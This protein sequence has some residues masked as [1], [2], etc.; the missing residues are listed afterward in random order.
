MTCKHFVEVICIALAFFAVALP[1]CIILRKKTDRKRL[2][3]LGY[4]FLL[5]WGVRFWVCLQ[6]GFYEE[7]LNIF[8]KLVDS[9]LH[10]LQTFSMDE[11]YTLYLTFGKSCLQAHGF[12]F[13]PRAYGIGISLLN[14]CAPVLG[15]AVLL[16]ILVDFFPDLKLWIFTR[17][18]KFVFSELNNDAVT[19]A[20]D[21]YRNQ[22]YRN[23][24]SMGKFDRKPVLL[25]LNVYRDESETRTE[26]LGRAKALGAV[27][28]NTD[29]LHISLKRS[30]TVNYFLIDA[31]SNV[32]ICT[33]TQLL[34][35]NEDDTLLWPMD[36]AQK[37]PITRI[38]VFGQDDNGNT[39]IRK[40]CAEHQ[41]VY[42]NVLVRP[43]QEHMS[44]AT[45]LMYDVP[46][47]LPLFSKPQHAQGDLHLTV[48]G[49]GELA[50]EV[51]KAFYWCGQ[52]TDVRLH[53]RVLAPDGKQMEQRIAERYPELLESCRPSSPLLQIRPFDPSARMNPPYCESMDFY[54][55]SD[56][57]QVS[58]YPAAV[59]RNTDYY[60]VALE[61]DEENLRITNQLKT[62]IARDLLQADSQEHPVIAPAIEEQRLAQAVQLPE[63]G[64]YEPYVVPFAS[65]ESRY[66]CKN[67]FL[68]NFTE[69]DVSIKSIYQK[70]HQQNDQKDIYATQSS[71]ARAV[72][73]PYK[74]FGLHLL[75]Q[76][77][78]TEDVATRYLVSGEISLTTAQE[79]QFAWLEHR[80]WNAFLRSQSFTCPTR[81]QY[82]RFFAQTGNTKS[83]VLKLHPCLVESQVEPTALKVLPQFTD[84]AYDY[85]DYVTMYTYRLKSSQAGKEENLDD[86]RRADYKKYDYPAYDSAFLDLIRPED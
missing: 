1:A 55:I 39:L 70:I 60:V 7:T 51:F 33:L 54:D 16:D 52:M 29:I 35:P 20:E 66:S 28:L 37:D 42:D 62:H 75:R 14:I 45:N 3:F 56:L 34:E 22:N 67:V 27:C 30:K 68:T 15:G 23:L 47:F 24:I 40:I 76:V 41:K 49:S 25:F 74:L 59:I 31:D 17:R 73:A 32:N 36:P 9:F 80:R 83:I 48:L 19:L 44:A 79:N 10:S 6:P 11:D 21:I 86:L 38:F 46:L 61:T 64:L 65:R 57:S 8:E 12:D 43:I 5:I 78:L 13:L 2:F 50:E 85:L 63:P 58:Q 69:K 72:H 71:V 26:L 82:A 77:K 84:P 81:E 4:L 18:H 53:V